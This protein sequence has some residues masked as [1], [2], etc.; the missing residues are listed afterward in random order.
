MIKKLFRPNFEIVLQCIV[1]EIQKHLT[2]KFTQNIDPN[3]I[4]YQLRTD[5]NFTQNPVNAI[6]FLQ[7]NFSL[8][9]CLYN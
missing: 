2:N 9:Q 7:Y 4:K 3:C 1:L 6:H 8:H 5:E